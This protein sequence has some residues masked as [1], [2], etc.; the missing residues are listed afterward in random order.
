M[1]GTIRDI[2]FEEQS[3]PRAFGPPARSE[4]GVCDSALQSTASIRRLP[5][6]LSPPEGP[7]VYHLFKCRESVTSTINEF[8]IKSSKVFFPPKVN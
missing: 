8:L 6:A 7:A 5:R 4:V 2:V 3:S 1:K